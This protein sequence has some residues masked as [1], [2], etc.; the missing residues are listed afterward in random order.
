VI[1]AAL[2][3]G[4]A[5]RPDASHCGPHANAADDPQGE[6]NVRDWPLADIPIALRNIRLWGES[7]APSGVFWKVK[8]LTRIQE[9]VSWDRQR[10][11]AVDL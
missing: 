6:A 11:H 10:H 2:A 9:V 5:V 3:A 1:A 8:C 4:A 7:D